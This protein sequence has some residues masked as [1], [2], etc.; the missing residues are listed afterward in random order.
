MFGAL[1]QKIITGFV[2]LSMV[3]FSSYEG[4]E[5]R[6]SEMNVSLIENNIFLQTRLENAFENDFE[7][8]FQLG[9]AIDIRFK[10]EVASE[11]DLLFSETFFHTVNYDPLEGAYF[12]ELQERKETIVTSSWQKLIKE[13]SKIE[14]L[15][16]L[17]KKKAL[18]ISIEASLPTIQFNDE[19]VHDLMIL[20]KFKT[21]KQLIILQDI[22]EI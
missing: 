18:K 9:K 21:P 4:N 17:E 12:L 14:F 19:K 13:I 20:W 3:L 5:P 2:S 6:F 22:N 1:S 10:I 15:H 16:R 8:I 7:R 11:E